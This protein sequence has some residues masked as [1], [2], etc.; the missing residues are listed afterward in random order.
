MIKRSVS[1]CC[2][3]PVKVLQGANIVLC[4]GYTKL[5]PAYYE[6]QQALLFQCTKCGRATKIIA[7]QIT[8]E[9]AQNETPISQIIL[10]L[11]NCNCPIFHCCDFAKQHIIADN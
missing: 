4:P 7:G 3:A 8:E 9:E 10:P 6:K 5:C 2:E 1:S 11:P